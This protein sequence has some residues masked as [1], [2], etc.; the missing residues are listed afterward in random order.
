MKEILLSYR[1]NIVAAIVIYMIRRVPYTYW[2]G[3]L[4]I[5]PDHTNLSA[6]KIAATE[7]T[8]VRY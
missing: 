8:I 3:I 5:E 2:N 1:A 6:L 7:L 4:S